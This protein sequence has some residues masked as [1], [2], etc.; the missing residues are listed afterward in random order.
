MKEE[1][2]ALEANNTQVITDLPPNKSAIGCHW[3][4]KIKHRADGSIEQYKA[5]L[6]AKGYTQL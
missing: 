6:V 1:I 2:N 3:V 5:R 4:Y